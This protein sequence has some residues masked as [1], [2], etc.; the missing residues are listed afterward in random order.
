[1]TSIWFMIVAVTSI[2]VVSPG[3]GPGGAGLLVG[4]GE[5]EFL[6]EVL[7]F[8]NGRDDLGDAV[9]LDVRI[10]P[11]DLPEPDGLGP[12]P[13]V[14]EMG[15]S[16]RATLLAFAGGELPLGKFSCAKTAWLRARRAMDRLCRDLEF[17]KRDDINLP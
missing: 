11:D 6:F 17:E 16:V 1:M 7:V 9:T 5:A 10:V 15:G 14:N 2:V 4:T 8:V 3:G 12:R 13:L